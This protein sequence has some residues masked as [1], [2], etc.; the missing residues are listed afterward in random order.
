M[1]DG[2]EIVT[3]EYADVSIAVSSPK[4][5][6]VPVVRNAERMNLAEIETEIK[7]LAH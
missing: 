4:G 2:D 5:L 3:Y 6:V 7:R 1:I